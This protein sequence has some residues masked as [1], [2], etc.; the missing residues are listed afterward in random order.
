MTLPFAISTEPN[1]SFWVTHTGCRKHDRRSFKIVGTFQTADRLVTACELR[2]ISPG[3][4]LQAACSPPREASSVVL[5]F[6]ALDVLA[7]TV[8]WQTSQYFGVRFHSTGQ[9]RAFANRLALQQNMAQLGIIDQRPEDARIM[10]RPVDV[11]F[12]QSQ[13]PTCVTVR[14]ISIHGVKFTGR[15]RAQTGDLVRIGELQGVIERVNENRFDVRFEPP[16]FSQ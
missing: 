11:F 12:G 6:N 2:G 13:K 16:S 14:D 4:A 15:C 1:E 5:T 9:P 3:G 10:N 8:V 7:G